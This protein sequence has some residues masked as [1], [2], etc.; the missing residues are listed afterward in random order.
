MRGIATGKLGF[1]AGIALLWAL[2]CAFAAP[3]QAQAL[4]AELLLTEGELDGPP[5]SAPVLASS[6]ADSPDELAYLTMP[7]RDAGYWVRL[8][9]DRDIQAGEGR[10]L[11]LRGAR[12]RGPVTYYPPGAAPRLI[13]DAENGGPVLMRRGWVLPLPN[14]WT[15][16]DVAYLRVGGNTAEAMSLRF[17]TVPEIARQE[18]SDS[19][20][21]VAAFT[22]LMLMALAMVGIWFAFRDLVY[23]F[24]GA[25]LSCAA[26]YLL[27]VSGDAAEMWGLSGIASGRLTVNWSVATL[28]T[29]F[30]L[31]FSL[32]FLELP[33]LLPRLALMARTLQWA[34]IVWL[35]VLLL[36]RE[37]VHGFWY[38]GGNVLLLM[39]I[40]L[41]FV[42][43][44]MAWRR[45]APYAG[46]Y[47]LGWTP[48]LLFVGVLAA[49]P[50][51][52]GRAEW[53]DRGL[54]LAAV[55]ESGVLALAL[56]QHAANR[57][58]L[59]LLAR[60][61]GDRDPLTGTLNASALRLLLETWSAPGSLGLK[62][63]GLLLLDLDAFGEVNARYG[64]AV[65]DALLQ[66]ALSRIR[67]VLRPDDTIAR[68]DGDSFAV[69]AECE[70]VDCELLG[71]RLADAFSQRPFRID[72]HEIAVSASVGL[73]MAQR[74]E[75]VQ[76]LLDRAAQALLSARQAG[77]NTVGVAPAAVL[78]A[79]A[80]PEAG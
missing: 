47:L 7:R 73:A 4:K 26:V 66:Q 21:M 10:V 12:A 34:N 33:R 60:Q 79:E 30:Q 71:R 28:A 46:Y 51:G 35:A 13:N 22:A 72:G 16:G 20:F 18:R 32:R 56:S 9:V 11:V 70:R 14:G 77:R 23:L 61:S 64:R 67:G 78:P 53:A 39:G 6:H 1:V 74:G 69:V 43:A 58:R 45:G 49:Y 59:A 5:A 41:M 36:L 62:R 76:A 80:E 25:Y 44:V 38:I 37:R 48:L 42:A 19:R 40:P 3:V 57:H 54:A 50:F 15:R 31:G 24:Y 2:A 52:V 8:T 68:M 29:I 63:H 27:L 75:P 55:L 17:S 65:G